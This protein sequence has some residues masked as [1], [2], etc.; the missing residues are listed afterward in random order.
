MRAWRSFVEGMALGEELS[1]L[2]LDPG[3]IDE[4]CDT[5]PDLGL[6]DRRTRVRT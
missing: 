2:L 1:G 3:A 4:L 5:L 6:A